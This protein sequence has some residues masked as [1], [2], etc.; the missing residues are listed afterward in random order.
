MNK[1]QDL[2]E[3]VTKQATE[4]ELN[5][6]NDFLHAIQQKQQNDAP[7]YLNAIFQMDTQYKQDQCTVTMP[8]TPISH[9]SF[10]MPHGGIIATLADNAMGFLIN[11]DLRS[12]GKGAVTTNMTVHYVKSSTEKNLIATATY[13]HKGRQT[14][15]MECTVTQPDGRKIAYATGSFFVINPPTSSK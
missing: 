12:E 3:T 10:N 11:K 2:F 13:L 7:T 6:V 8:I 15:V 9:N 5:L 14:I 4:Q 1:L